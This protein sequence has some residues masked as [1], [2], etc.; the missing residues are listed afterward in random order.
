MLLALEYDFNYDYNFNYD[1]RGRSLIIFSSDQVVLNI[2]SSVKVSYKLFST[3]YLYFPF[4]IQYN[5]GKDVFMNSFKFLS[6]NFS[7][8]KKGLRCICMLPQYDLFRLLLFA[9]KC[10]F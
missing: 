3:H 5:F 1:S 6:G 9:I 4:K 10:L 2:V 7:K 8:D